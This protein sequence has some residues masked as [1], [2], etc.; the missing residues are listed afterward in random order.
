MGCAGTIKITTLEAWIIIV[1]YDQRPAGRSKISAGAGSNDKGMSCAVHGQAVL[2]GLF[3]RALPV[4][5]Q[6]ANWCSATNLSRAVII[7]LSRS[8]KRLG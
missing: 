2:I 4:S 8:D 1:I 3:M 5:P 6:H 7:G